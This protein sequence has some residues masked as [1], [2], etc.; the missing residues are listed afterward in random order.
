MCGE[1]YAFAGVCDIG[2]IDESRFWGHMRLVREAGRKQKPD[3]NKRASRRVMAGRGK[4]TVD[5]E[6]V[7]VQTPL[8]NP[9]VDSPGYVSNYVRLL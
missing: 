7:P 4:V 2:V 6:T 9:W 3:R 5:P 1:N 8:S